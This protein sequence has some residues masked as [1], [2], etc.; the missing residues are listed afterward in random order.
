[1]KVVVCN[2]CKHQFAS[3]KANKDI[4]CPHCGNNESLS[5]RYDSSEHRRQN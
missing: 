2:K 1:M 5:I 4:V 3:D